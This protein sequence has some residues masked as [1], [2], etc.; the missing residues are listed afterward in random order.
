MNNDLH[1]MWV[2]GHIGVEGNKLARSGSN[3]R[4]YGPEPCLG[5][6]KASVNRAIAVRVI[7]LASFKWHNLATCRQTKTFPL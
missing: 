3:L 2:P 1:I 5:I 6:A 7:E 4:F